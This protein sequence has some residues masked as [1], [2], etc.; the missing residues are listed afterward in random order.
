M[1]RSLYRLLCSNAFKTLGARTNSHYYTTTYSYPEA[2]NG[3]ENDNPNKIVPFTTSNCKLLAAQGAEILKSG[4]V[5]ATPTDTVY[6]IACDA[7]N[8]SA[9][10]RIYEI[11]GRDFNKPIAIC[12][13]TIDEVYHWGKITVS[14]LLLEDLLPGPVTLVFE[15]LPV[16]N[17]HLNPNTSLIGIRIPDNPFIIQLAKAHCGPIALTSANPSSTPSTLCIE[18]FKTLW[19]SL[20]LVIDGGRL[21]SCETSEKAARAGSTVIDLSH[22]GYFRIIRSGS[23][24]EQSIHILRNKH[25]LLEELTK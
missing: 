2:M 23:A 22:P 17:S 13:S 21:S 1:V 3:N 8:K 12:V 18:E 11:K 24:Q 25:G 9:I 16:L 5:I 6:G 20:D 4:A 10:R 14:R 19:S 15:R 7:Q